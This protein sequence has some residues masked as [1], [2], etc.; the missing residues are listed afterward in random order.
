MAD[1]RQRFEEYDIMQLMPKKEE[2]SLLKDFYLELNLGEKVLFSLLATGAL[3]EEAY[4]EISDWG[5]RTHRP[6]LTFEELESVKARRK[7]IQNLLLRLATR[8]LVEIEGKKRQRLFKLTQK[9]LL[10]L[11]SKF[12]QI[13]F[14]N[15]T[16][17][18]L[19]RVVIYDIE[20]TS[21]T[22]RNLLR[23][24]LRQL[25]FNLVQRSVWFSPYPIEN[26]LER[27]LKEERLW[28]KIMVFKTELSAEDNQRLVKEFYP[29]LK[30]VT[31]VRKIGNIDK[32]GSGRV[33]INARNSFLRKL[34]GG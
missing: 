26:E 19:W 27:F 9:G 3:A 30:I 34:K 16:W 15:R 17:D 24:K 7:T 8:K 2:L 20:E 13:K 23:S 29:H 4:V 1:D 11:L 12:P 25:G 10:R 5:I 14:H 28:E 18:G 32:P 6:W 21:R 31:I 22:L 33:Q